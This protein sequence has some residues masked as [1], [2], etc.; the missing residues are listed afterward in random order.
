MDHPNII[1]L[2]DVFEDDKYLH[3]V[4]EL[5]TGGE[6]FD[7]IIEKTKSAEG[8]YSEQDAATIIKS[9]LN[10]IEYC[11]HVHNI[12]H[13]D[14]K[15]ENF[16]FATPESD[17]ELKIIDFGLSRY[18]DEIEH[19]STKV[20]TPY[21]IAPEVLSRGKY[22]KECDL[23]S[24]GVVCYVLLCGYPPFYGDTDAEIFASV[25][26]GEF[27]FPSP[28]WDDISSQAKQFIR[29]CLKTDASKRPT[30]REAL[31]HP[32]FTV[33][34]QSSV[35]HT[36]NNIK[37][38]LERFINMNKLKRAALQVIAEQLTEAELHGL[39]STFETLDMNKDGKLTYSEV[40][41]AL[42]AQG[43]DMLKDEL[44]SIMEGLGVEESNE[45]QYSEFLAAT[46][47]MNHAIR[48]E[49]IMRAF[50]QFDKDG[51]GSLT[52][53][54]LIEIMGS[55]D[56]ARELVGEIDLN[57]DGV[58]SYEEF[59]A[60]IQGLNNH[61][62]RYRALMGESDHPDAL[63][64]DADAKLSVSEGASQEKKKASKNFFSR[65]KK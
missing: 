60:M 61:S 56:H 14:L 57:G 15:P 10:A 48:E 17:S 27:D 19:M 6:L 45:I 62:A 55:E 39:R 21:Y 46:M 5:C 58:I 22:D 47:D 64:K 33:A 49:N 20:G 4:T 8:H 28:D 54:E 9:V 25:K 31:E 37:G 29:A 2:V 30:A 36:M 13:R 59:K 32:W 24:I 53:N 44:R 40:Q 35:G 1:R 26:K 63:S 43:F 50:Q 38:S 11:H 23:W 34:S 7:R 65:S 41:S 42:D 12:C 51:S 16:L 3:L 52:M 18:D